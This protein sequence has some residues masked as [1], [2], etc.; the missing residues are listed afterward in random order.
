MNAVM[1]EHPS[2]SVLTAYSLGQLG[3]DDL[4]GVDGHLA[5][6]D[7]CR[8][9]VEGVVPDTLLSL[10]RSAATEPDSIVAGVE[11]MRVAGA[12]VLRSPGTVNPNRDPGFRSTST[13]AT[14]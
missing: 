13:P 3:E 10:L 1:Q 12:E 7:V 4:V 9:V 11:E 2:G 6:C 14:R 5:D 8:Q